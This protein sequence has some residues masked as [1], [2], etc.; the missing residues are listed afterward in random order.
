MIV[1]YFHV[2]SGCLQRMEEVLDYCVKVSVSRQARKC[3]NL[4]IRNA[5]CHVREFLPDVSSSY[6][7]SLRVPY[8]ILL[9]CQGNSYFSSSF[10]ALNNPFCIHNI[11]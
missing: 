7:N 9:L 10:A 1:L 6:F 8:L 2:A 4:E 5:G 11:T 3:L